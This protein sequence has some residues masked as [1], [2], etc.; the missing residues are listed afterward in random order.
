MVGCQF[1]YAGVTLTGRAALLQEMSSRVFVVYRQCIA[2]LLIAPLAYFSSV[3]INQNIYFEGLYLASSSAASALANLI[4]AITFVMA[5]TL[6][7]EKFHLRSLRNMAKIIG[8]VFCVAGAAAMALL[9]GPCKC[10]LPGSSFINSMDVPGGSFTIWNPNIDCGAQYQ[11]MEL[12]FPIAII[13]LLLCSWCIARRGPL[14]SAMFNP[15][16]TVIVTLLACTFLHEELY[17]GSVMGGLAVI[18]GLY[19]VLWGKAK[20]HQDKEGTISQIQKQND[21]TLLSTQ[22]SDCIIHLEEP[23]LPEKSAN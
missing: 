10:M 17:T 20:D 15:L 16:C 21:E 5:Y 6:G 8:T 13:L 11:I 7:L 14:F 22:V 1:L 18:V 12:K 9:K 23:L 3:T 2:F 4:P 19:V